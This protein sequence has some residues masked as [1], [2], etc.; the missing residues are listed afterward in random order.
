MKPPRVILISPGFTADEQD[1]N[2]LPTLQ[3]YAEALLQFGADVHILSLDYPFHIRPYTWKGARVYPCGGRNSRF[4]R[5]LVWLRALHTGR[6]LLQPGAAAVLHSFWLGWPSAVGEY[7]SRRY[8]VP[9]LCTLMGQDASPQNG[10]WLQRLSPDRADRLVVLSDFHN[11]Q[12][13]KNT[14]FNATHI[15]PW[16]VSAAEIPADVT[17]ERLIDLLGVGSMIPL[18]NWNKW[19]E[20]AALLH[21]K[22]PKLRAELIGGGPERARL[23]QYARQLGLSGVVHFTGELPRPE[24]LEKMRRSKLLLHCSEYESQGYVLSEAVMNGCAVVSTP[25]GLAPE[26]CPCADSPKL[27]AALCE[28]ALHT[29]GIERARATH[30]MDW[31]VERYGELYESLLLPYWGD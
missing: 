15:I 25:V 12:F 13:R 22:Q 30:T 10:H 17:G 14:G 8:G 28:K 23:E 6:S 1:K 27:L 2:C 11:E 4:R 5:P 9:H 7:L 3:L 19:L 16:G 31:T 20:I 18:K 26:L 21:R 29:A 24:V